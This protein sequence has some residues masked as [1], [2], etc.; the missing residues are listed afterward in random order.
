MPKI[1]SI[2]VRALAEFA[3][4]KGDLVPCVSWIG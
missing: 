1:H 4:Q 3:L 2:N